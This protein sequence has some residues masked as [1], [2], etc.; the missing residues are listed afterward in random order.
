MADPDFTI[1][2]G[3]AWQPT[4]AKILG[5]LADQDLVVPVVGAGKA[6]D[7]MGRKIPFAGALGSGRRVSN[8]RPSAWEFGGGWLR[9]RD[10]GREGTGK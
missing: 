1:G 9:E 5:Y 4:D 7:L 10:L 2:E 8:P 6:P 3:E